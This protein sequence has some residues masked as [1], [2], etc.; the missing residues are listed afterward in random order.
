VT[1]RLG[2]APYVLLLPS[3][4]YL[5]IFFATPMAQAFALAL[6]DRDGNWT[7][8]SVMRMIDDP[9]FR[10]AVTTTIALVILVMPVQFVLAMSMALVVNAKLKGQGLW[11]YLYALPLGI[12]ELAAGIVWVSIF[13]QTGWLNTILESLGVIDRPIIWQSSETPWLL[14]MTIV[15]AEAWRATAIIMIILVA[16]LQSIPAEFLEAADVYGATTWQKVRRVILPMLRPSLQVALILRTI[17]AFQV[18]ATVVALAGTGLTVLSREAQRWATDIDNDHVAAGYAGLILLLSLMATLLALFVVA[19]IYLIFVAAVT[20]RELAFAYPRAIIPSEI[21][22]ETISFFLNA[23]GVVPSFWRSVQVALITL[24]IALSIGA[25]A[26]YALA[27]YAFRGRE[28]YRLTVLSTRAF[29]IVILA[30]P[31]AVTYIRWGLDD[32]VIGVA[33]M[34]TALALPFTVLITSSVFMSVP[35][36]LE[37][38]AQTLG[39]TPLQA[40]LKVSLPLA[41]PG[42]AAAAIFTWVLSWNDVFAAAILTLTNQTLPAKI[43]SALTQSPIYYQ[44][45]AGFVMLVP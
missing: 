20:P 35:R 28:A 8:A 32:S 1:A 13:T 40:F 26:G 7:L 18:F 25:P 2:W 15:L 29:P 37:E 34:H 4:V 45:A 16:G 27:R 17:L 36:D 14:I 43:L 3:L 21:S 39:C 10:D 12:S 6:Q 11:L 9:N 44:F 5:A 23:S 38:A 24:A 19:P 42:L 41:L 33:F 30:I 22:T 31:I